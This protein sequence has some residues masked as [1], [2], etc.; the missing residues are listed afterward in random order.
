M[1]LQ[2]YAQAK[3]MAALLLDAVQ[4]Q[5]MPPWGAQE[6][7]TC[8]PQ[9][10]WQHDLRLTAQEV[11]VLS[12][13]LAQGTPEG[14]AADAPPSQA[15]DVM[16]LENADTLAVPAAPFVASGQSDQL[17]CFVLDTQFAAETWLNGV[18]VVPGNP[19]VVHHVLLFLDRK[20]A[21]PAKADKDGQ[22]TCFGDAGVPDQNLLAAWAPGSIPMQ[23]P[24]GAGSVIPKGARLV[25]Q[26]HYHP[27]PKQPESD[28]TKVQLRF[29]KS[30][31]TLLGET[32]LVGNADGQNGADGLLPGPNDPPSGPAFVIPAG[33]TNHTEEMRFTIPQTMGKAAMP[34][35]SIYAVGT[36]MHYVGKGMRIWVERTAPGPACAA[37]QLAPLSACLAAQCPG[38]A[39]VVLAQCAQKAC[40][41]T[42]QGLGSACTGCLQAEVMAGKTS[43]QVFDT[44][45]TQVTGVQTGLDEECLIETPK[46]DFS[47]Q[48][49]YVYDAPIDKLPVV[50]PG[51]KLRMKC[52]YDNS[53]NNPAVAAALQSQGKSVPQPV[54]LG[55]QT[56]DEMC[57]AVIQVLYKKP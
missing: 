51:D 32:L 39:G 8:K 27:D 21:S 11:G 22:Y 13:W 56:L 20:A 40:A 29:L 4:G 54:K 5:R 37:Q 49:I 46:W 31:P 45:T 16:A 42:V 57:L 17:R 36:H 53:L 50:G 18:Q 14:S 48:R 41:Q 33:A 25:M 38:L 34:K 30:A 1:P 24:A 44:C 43:Q 28:L 52:T 19:K 3:P 12:Q 55:E 6:T 35:L 15:Q 47:W 23:Y 7:A 26:V 2:T 10:G 9:F